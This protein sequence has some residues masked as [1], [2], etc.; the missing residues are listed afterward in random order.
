[1][2]QVEVLLDLCGDRVW[3]FAL[4]GLIEVEVALWLCYGLG[5]VVAFALLFPLPNLGLA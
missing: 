2:N 3:A 1:M 4:L 5:R